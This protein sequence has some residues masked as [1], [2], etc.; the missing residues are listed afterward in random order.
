[1]A[2]KRYKITINAPGATRIGVRQIAPTGKTWAL[3][4]APKASVK[5]E[6]FAKLPPSVGTAVTGAAMIEIKVTWSKAAGGGTV[7]YAPRAVGSDQ[8]ITL[9]APV[10]GGGELGDALGGSA[11][12]AGLGAGALDGVEAPLADDGVFD[13][14]IGSAQAS[15]DTSAAPQSFGERVAGA[16]LGSVIFGG[17]VYLVRRFFVKQRKPRKR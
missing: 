11:G 2:G 14:L 10:L 17:S 3:K 1:M 15:T 13:Y 4:D 12:D 9:K 6:T 16:V 5:V 7:T 8:T